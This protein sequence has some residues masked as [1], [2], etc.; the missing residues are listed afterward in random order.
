MYISEIAIHGFKS[1]AKKVRLGFGEGITGV[2]GPNGCGKTNIVDAVRW[3]LG[4]QKYRMLRGSKIDDFIFNGSDSKKPLNFCEVSLIVHNNKGMLPVEYTDVEI[5]R[6]SFRSGES[7]YMINRTP[8][9]LKDIQNLFI[10]T[11]MGADAYSVIELKMIEDILS[12]GAE[13]RRKMFEEAAG[14]NKYKLQRKSTLRKLEATSV[15][16]DRVNDIV[17]EV[18]N[19]VHSL[20]LQLKRYDRHA[21]LAERLEKREIQLAYL[22]RKKTARLLDPLRGKIEKLQK[23][24]LTNEKEEEKRDNDLEGMKKTYRKQQEELKELQEKLDGLS[25]EKEDLSS[26]ILVLGEKARST[27]RT[28]E[29]LDIE[30]KEN[31]KK[32]QSLEFNMEELKVEKEALEPRIEAKRSEYERR[33]EELRLIED[34]HLEAEGKLDYLNSRQLEHLR[35]LESVL[36]LQ[37]RTQ[38]ILVEKQTLLKNLE[39]EA[40]EF[41]SQRKELEQS[42]SKQKKERARIEKAISSDRKQLNE[43]DGK[44]VNL[45]SS[46]HDSTLKFHRI[47]SQ[48][49]SLE[50]QLQFF[51][52]LIESKEGY[53]SGVRHILGRL[54]DFPEVLGTLA[55]LIELDEK[56]NLAISAALGSVAYSLVCEKREQALQII[57][58]LSEEKKGKI[59]I[60]PLDALKPGRPR[61]GALPKLAGVVGYA[62][63]L[64]NSEKRIVPLIQ[65]VLHDVV[66]VEDSTAARALWKAG[67]FE[68]SIA[69]LQGRFYDRSGMVTSIN[70]QEEA[71]LLGRKEKITQLDEKIG[72]LVEEGNSIR[73]ELKKLDGR[74]SEYESRHHQLS[75]N[76]GGLIDELAETEKKITRNEYSISQKVESFQSTTHQIVKTREEILQLEKNLD[77]NLPKIGEGE[78]KQKNYQEKIA[79]IKSELDQIKERREEEN[80]SVQDVRFELIN[81]E[82]ERDNLGYKIQASGASVEELKKAGVE[83]TDEVEQ[84]ETQGEELKSE[85]KTAELSLKKVTAQYRKEVAIKDLKEQSVEGVRERIDDLQTELRNRQR[86][87][88]RVHDEM[89][90]AELQTADYESQND[91]IENRIREKFQ[92]EIP[93]VMDV[94]ATG[95]ELSLEIERIRGSIERIGPI[96][97]AVRE[98]CEEEGDRLDFLMKQRKD[99][100]DSEGSLLESM[101]RI[102]ATARSQFK[103]TFSRIRKN[104]QKTFRLFFEGGDG[105]LALAGGD[106]DPLEANIVI[107]AKPPGKRTH[108]LRALSS[109]EKALTAIALLFSIYQV[110]PSPFCILDE[111]DAPLDDNN[112]DRFI[113]VLQKFSEE[114]QFIIVT[115][116]KLTM[117][118]A[119]HLY[120]VTMEQSGVSKIVS[121][122]F[123]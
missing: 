51:R 12:E 40:E 82:N 105:D 68:G 90:R 32:I 93:N 22:R 92:T 20:K 7:Q 86:E 85:S 120:G 38:E 8:C 119:S 17:G 3:V 18:E 5:A 112:V 57:D 61:K 77:R 47:A 44:I 28:I 46:R 95:D 31:R 23:E 29:R 110:K 64:V 27:S 102:D 99:L 13:D 88:E 39:S 91:L 45:R 62:V 55:D 78:E 84:L 67:G 94:K 74:L 123:D 108:N 16:L 15:D 52:E 43:L 53:P 36:G 115:H 50:S 109:G 2:V 96:N 35:K 33:K 111:V 60:I 97:M 70:G 75:V 65:T 116:N 106:D 41:K 42:Q 79:Q 11:G 100:E 21:K 69:D 9:R 66:F 54:K 30:G 26:Q 81:L 14:I 63:D 6:R 58:E 10:D 76:L 98:E 118:S 80:S 114:T 4:E 121:V 56:Y 83:L 103:E 71:G 37:G 117:E 34:K 72:A 73:E 1:F 59:T 101:N 89:K 25:A 122:K 87:R 104:Y 48:V 19:K 24:L 113:R 107:M 49:E